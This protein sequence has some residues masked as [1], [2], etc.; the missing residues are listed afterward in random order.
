MAEAAHP[1]PAQPHIKFDASGKPYIEA[2]RCRACGAVV[3]EPRLAC[4][5]CAARDGFEAAPAAATGKLIAYS[6]VKRSYPGIPV[7][8]VSAVVELDDGLTL[9]ANLVGA[10]FEPESIAGN[11]PVRVRF[12][13][14]LG[15]TD[16]DGRT[17]V[18]YEFEPR[19]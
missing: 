17:Y 4:P 8:F 19:G 18:G 12:N 14:A 15:R 6:I 11:L 3:A 10:G 9:K 2:H 13:D 7:P 1:Q 16:K 5:A